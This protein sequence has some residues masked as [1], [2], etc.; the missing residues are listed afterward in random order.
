M[1]AKAGGRDNFRSLSS[2][3]PYHKSISQWTSSL[4]QRLSELLN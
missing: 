1:S 2:F 3:L 4:S